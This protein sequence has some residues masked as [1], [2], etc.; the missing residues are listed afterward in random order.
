MT[1]EYRK[2]G[3]SGFKVPEGEES[4]T[5]E[6]WQVWQLELTSGTSVGS[7]SRDGSQSLPPMTTSSNKVTPSKPP[8]QCH[9]LG[10]KSPNVQGY[11]R[12]PFKPHLLLS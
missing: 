10:T 12:H 9:Q 6:K 7:R 5:A 1:K 3:L 11:T 8:K 4:I 2:K